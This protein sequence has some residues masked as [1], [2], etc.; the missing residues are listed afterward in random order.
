MAQAEEAMGMPVPDP[1]VPD[2]TPAERELIDMMLLLIDEVRLLRERMADGPTVPTTAPPK[3][4][5]DP[6]MLD[7]NRAA[8]YLGVLTSFIRNLVARRSVVHYKLG[9]RVMFAG[10]TSISSLIRTSEIFLTWLPGN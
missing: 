1:R 3:A 4:E 7:V 5:A 9:G 10:R 8:G 2:H 6:K